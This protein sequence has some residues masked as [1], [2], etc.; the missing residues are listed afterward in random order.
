MYVTVIHPLYTY[1]NNYGDYKFAPYQ[2]YK[3]IDEY[4]GLIQN[5]GNTRMLLRDTIFR[6]EFKDL[7]AELP[8]THAILEDKIREGKD[9]RPDYLYDK[10]TKQMEPADWMADFYRKTNIDL[11]KT[12]KPD[13]NGENLK[14]PRKQR[15]ESSDQ[16]EQ[17]DD[18]DRIYKL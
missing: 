12:L 2:Q 7:V 5:P 15:S 16:D 6:F 17:S 8:C 18:Q 13:F 10:F 1:V 4:V 11:K 3:Y 9:T 14:I